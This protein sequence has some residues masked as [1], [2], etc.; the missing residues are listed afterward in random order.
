MTPKN[1]NEQEN[2]PISDI[3]HGAN[4]QSDLPDQ[5]LFLHSNSSA[6]AGSV[7]A[8]NETA[9]LDEHVTDAVVVH[10]GKQAIKTVDYRKPGALDPKKRAAVQVS[11]SLE[12]S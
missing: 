9:V 6:N 1:A 5:N 8:E 3:Q 11:I 12:K 10:A 4:R 2:T 7:D